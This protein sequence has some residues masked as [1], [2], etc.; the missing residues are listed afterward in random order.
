MIA[1]LV[2]GHVWSDRA[3]HPGE[4]GPQLRQPPLEGGVTAER[5]QHVSEVNAGRS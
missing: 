3:H 1:H 2:V 4:I 5:D